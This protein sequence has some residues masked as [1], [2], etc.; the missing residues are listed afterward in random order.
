MEHAGTFRVAGNHLVTNGRSADKK[1]RAKGNGFV[2]FRERLQIGVGNA[3]RAD[4]P[5]VVG[6]IQRALER[7]RDFLHAGTGVLLDGDVDD[8]RQLV[9]FQ[10]HLHRAVHGVGIGKACRFQFF[11]CGQGGICTDRG[12]TGAAGSF[13]C[14]ADNQHVAEPRCRRDGLG[15]ADLNI[16]DV[17]DIQRIQNSH[18]L[19]SIFAPVKYPASSCA[20]P[21]SAPLSVCVYGVPGLRIKAISSKV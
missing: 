16:N 7:F 20:R 11:Q 19:Y 17:F 21:A 12:R 8:V 1:H 6:V 18:S 10:H 15:N 9:C 3:H 14:G 2:G 13:R 5:K 4:A